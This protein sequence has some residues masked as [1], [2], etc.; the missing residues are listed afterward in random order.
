MRGPDMSNKFL[1]SQKLLETQRT[2]PGGELM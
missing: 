2:I 1:R